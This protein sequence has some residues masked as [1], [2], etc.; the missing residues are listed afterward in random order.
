M[1]EPRR[2]DDSSI[3]GHL[4]G[5]NLKHRGASAL[6]GADAREQTFGTRRGPSRIIETRPYA[7]GAREATDT[8]NSVAGVAGR[9]AGWTARTTA[10]A[11]AAGVGVGG[12]AAQ[13]LL[14]EDEREADEALQDHAKDPL[15]KSVRKSLKSNTRPKSG[16]AGK[17][18]TGLKRAGKKAGNRPGSPARGGL[19]V[20]RKNAAN[21]KKS[22]AAASKASKTARSAGGAYR[23]ISAGLHGARGMQQAVVLALRAIQATYHAIVAAL[24]TVVSAKVGLIVLVIVVVLALVITIVSLIPG[25]GNAGDDEGDSFCEVGS[26]EGTEVK[27]VPKG[28]I[29][30]Y[31]QDALKN[32][33]IIIAVAQETGFEGDGEI[34]GLITAMQES[35][36]GMTPGIDKPNGD[37]DAGVFQQRQLPGWYGSLKQVNDI[38]YA[39]NAFFNGVTAD[40]KGGYGSAGG[41]KGF[42]HI[43]GLTDV[44]GWEDMAPG[45]AAQ[46]VQKSAFPDAYADHVDDAKKL[47]SGLSDTKVTLGGGN[48]SGGTGKKTHPA[49]G[50]PQTSPFGY[51]IHPISGERKLHTGVDFGVPCGEKVKA[52][53]NGKVIFSGWQGGY[54]NRVEID[55]GK[56]IVSTYNHAIK[57]TV[58]KGQNVKGGDTVTINGTTGSSTGCHL[59]FE[60]KKDGAYVDPVPYLP[61]N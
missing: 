56:G 50:Y 34:V 29:A 12:K 7:R 44:A 61:D 41:G 58:K 48:C 43:P 51:R 31:D 17:G 37:G 2:T 24:G 15:K 11:G 60:I 38:V 16:N 18:A 35:R 21:I 10:A 28:P 57:T 49:P 13:M 36:L 20:Q 22:A 26:G 46:K 54:G 42:G 19:T 32:A 33:A 53:N 55:H 1:K 25:F 14:D 27:N 52:W 8:I 30:T 40:K 39:S 47:I 9:A 4:G 5:L 23:G 59:H 6:T 3:N 45:T